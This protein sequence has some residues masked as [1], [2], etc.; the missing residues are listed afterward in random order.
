MF[1]SS[2]QLHV[3]RKS[4]PYQLNERN[5][6]GISLWSH[7]VRNVE[8]HLHNMVRHVGTALAVFLVAAYGY[9]EHTWEYVNRARKLIVFMRLFYTSDSLHV[10]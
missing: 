5:R 9:N 3:S 8:R 2:A 10:C 1:A 4:V 6:H 7:L